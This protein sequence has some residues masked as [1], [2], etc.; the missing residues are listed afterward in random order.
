MVLETYYLESRVGLL[1]SDELYEI[2]VER[3]SGWV[4]VDYFAEWCGPCKRFAPTLD[5]FS[6]QY[7]NVRFFKVDV[8]QLVDK[9]EDAN[10]QSMPTFVLYKNGKEVG[11]ISGA[12]PMRLSV[13]LNQTLA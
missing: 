11:R 10:I 8:E 3:G 13:L 2:E 1:D 9:A 12:D 5:K 4:L 6:T 7:Q